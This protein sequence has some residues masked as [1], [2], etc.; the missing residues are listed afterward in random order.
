VGSLP[1]NPKPPF[2]WAPLDAVDV[3]DP[4]RLTSPGTG[5]GPKSAIICSTAGGVNMNRI[6]TAMDADVQQGLAS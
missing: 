3:G 6:R 1:I 4:E 5:S 2:A